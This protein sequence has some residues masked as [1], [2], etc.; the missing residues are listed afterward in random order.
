M[1]NKEPLISKKDFVKQLNYIKETRD[2]FDKLTEA[3]E[4]LAPGFRCDFLPNLD[5]ETHIV[6]AL[7]L[8]MHENN[9]DSLIDYFLYELNFG[10]EK[11]SKD[12]IKY[13]GKTYDLSS[14]EKLYDALLEINFPEAA[15][16]AAASASKSDK[17]NK[18]NKK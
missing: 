3:M 7:N 12:A 4:D 9:D 1:I 13:Q 6:E 8:L 10:T 11:H 5:F 15:A 14:P 16:E 2:K 18:P 17:S